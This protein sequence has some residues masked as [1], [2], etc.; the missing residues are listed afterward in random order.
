MRSLA[1]VLVMVVAGALAAEEEPPLPEVAAALARIANEST[2]EISTMGRKSGKERTTPVWF[3][4]ADGKM[5]LQSGRDGKTD[6]YR[7]L[8]KNPALQVR[9]DGYLFRARATRMV[10]DPAEVERVHRLFLAKYT[11]ARLLSWVGSSIGRGQPVELTVDA[12]SVAR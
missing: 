2:V 10:T 3:V 8:E 12:V 9:Q 11:S 4:V 7:N 1:M 6:W 5:L